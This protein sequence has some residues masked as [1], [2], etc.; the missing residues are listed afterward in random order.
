[1]TMH[2]DNVIQGIGLILFAVATAALGDAIV[3]LSSAELSLWQIFAVRS[4]IAMVFLVTL[5]RIT[6]NALFPKAQFWT[7]LRTVLLVFAWIAYYTALT[8]LDLAIA[9]VAAYTNP[10]FTVLIAAVALRERVLMCQWLGVFLGFAGVVVILNPTGSAVQPALI[11][12]VLAALLYSVAV[13]LTRTKCQDEDYLAVAFNLHIGFVV[14]GVLGLCA[15]ALFSPSL[16]TTHINDFLLSG[17]TEMSPTLWWSMA[18]LGLLA[19]SFSLGVARAYQIA[20]PQIIAT[21][22]YGYVGFALFW[23]FIFFNEQPDMYE[24]IG[25]GLVVGAGMLV[26]SGSKPEKKTAVA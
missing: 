22:D 11:M 8:Y 23:G 6:H 14:A 20:P 19:A 16:E 4:A 13:I 5:A 18:A 7:A 15:V 2:Q 10:I 25:M 24:Y 3:K 9:A 17:W 1:M 12:P 21:Y 26:V